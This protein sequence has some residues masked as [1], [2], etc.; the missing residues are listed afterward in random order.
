MAQLLFGL[1]SLISKEVSQNDFFLKYESDIAILEYIDN[2]FKNGVTNDTLSKLYSIL[3]KSGNQKVFDY[4]IVT[5]LID[6]RAKDF[7]TT[8]NACLFFNLCFSEIN[9]VSHI[10]ASKEIFTLYHQI[11]CGEY[12]ETL[13]LSVDDK[14]S[15]ILKK[16]N[17]F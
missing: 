7:L 15:F 1:A 11:I 10:M 9:L 4:F 12:P 14:F 13:D 2:L 6:G 17:L 8:D 3:E 5:L 16:M